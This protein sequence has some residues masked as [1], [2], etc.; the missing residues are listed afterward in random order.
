MNQPMMKRS[1]ALLSPVFAILVLL[2]AAAPGQELRA[3]ASAGDVRRIEDLERRREGDPEAYLALAARIPDPAGK[4]RLLLAMGR[5]GDSRLAPAAAGVLESV[6]RFEDAASG[7]RAAVGTGLL[8]DA[9]LLALLAGRV[10]A[11]DLARALA[12]AGGL[13]GDE[14]SRSRVLDALRADDRGD[15]PE[16]TEFLDD[17]VVA[18]LVY[19]ARIEEPVFFGDAR[20]ILE[21]GEPLDHVRAALYLLARHPVRPGEEWTPLLAGNLFHGDP[22][23]AAYAARALGRMEG[24]GETEA[25]ILGL[26]AE[27]EGPR[28][29]TVERLR[30]LQSI[31]AAPPREAVAAALASTDPCLRRAGLELLAARGSLAPMEERAGMVAFC[32]EIVER[33]PE[34]DVRR[35]GVLALARLNFPT[36][37]EM[38]PRYRLG[39]P[40][41]LRGAFARVYGGRGSPGPL[42]DASYGDDPDRRVRLQWLEGCQ[43]FMESSPGAEASA[44]LLRLFGA[45]PAGRGLRA[46]GDSASN[47]VLARIFIPLAK[48]GGLEDPG[49]PPDGGEL[50]GWVRA[51]QG[52]T[53]IGDVEAHQAFLDL[54][55]ALP[56]QAG[57][58]LLRRALAT[59]QPALAGRALAALGA[60]AAGAEAAP[61]GP[62]AFC[63]VSGADLAEILGGRSEIVAVVATGR[64]DLTV[65]LDAAGAP[66]TVGNFL[67]LAG[68]GFFDGLL[69]HRVVPG[70]VVQAGCP[71]GD[72]Y[73]GPGFT[74][75]CEIGGRTYKRGTLGMALAG[76]DTGGSQWFI[77]HEAQPHLDMRYTVFGRLISGFD[78]LDALLP[79]D[80]I[81]RVR[82]QGE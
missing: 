68:G 27:A 47:G 24:A 16:R 25:A 81:L 72:G 66:A 2:P 1:R 60:G 31:E 14:P 41:A 74:I 77:C 29:V 33:D 59:G 4:S 3:E 38:A 9:S 26:A 6:D 20:R 82:V 48:E 50:A 40:F 54:A 15:V 44:R 37:D 62:P 76:K 18:R 35:A 17:P 10:P 39:E 55:A 69:F 58:P 12:L 19:G 32:A 49:G 21:R 73:G 13:P 80:R 53:P 56:P 30:A 67:R 11:A 34:A 65:A 75:P 28:F 70:F 45:G 63:P 79:G 51:R 78:V 5:S 22:A 43:E 71:R 36:L 61:A 8:H 7:T 64:G 46:Y 57:E 52:E 23:V 42:P